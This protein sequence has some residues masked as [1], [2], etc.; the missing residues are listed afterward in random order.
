[1]ALKSGEEGILT[2]SLGNPYCNPQN[3]WECY[4]MQQRDFADV[5]MITNLDM[6]RSS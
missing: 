4:I 1:M 6:E 5:I 3:L 2:T